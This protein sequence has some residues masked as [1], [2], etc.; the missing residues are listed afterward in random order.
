MIITID[1]PV[2]SGKSVVARALANQ[3]SFYYLYTGLLYRGL[4]YVLHKFYGYDDK[5][6]GNPDKKDIEDIFSKHK[7]RYKYLDGEAFIFFDGVDI[8][9]NLKTR[10]VDFWSSVIS[11][12]KI[13]RDAVMAIQKT[14][15]AKYDV[16]ADGRDMGTVIFPHAEFKFFLTASPEV[17]AERWRKF[18][19]YKGKNYSF[20]ESLK[21]I[22]DRDKRDREREL[23][24]LKKAD[25][26]I[27]VD[28]S[29]MNIDET[30]EFFK[31][32][33]GF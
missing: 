6:M 5:K 12:H 11:V 7:F 23:S 33:L 9:K 1:G 21:I 15:G 20:E 3:F 19:A 16:V 17:R 27:L 28:N 2:A 8:T 30:V 25:D 13:V 26:A 18:Q 31:S 10:E 14:I 22:L 32:H 4:A 24:P 29:E